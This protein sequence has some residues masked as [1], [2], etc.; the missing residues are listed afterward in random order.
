[1]ATDP[2][3]AVAH[4]VFLA[5]WSKALQST[6]MKHAD[7]GMIQ[8]G[9]AIEARLKGGDAMPDALQPPRNMLLPD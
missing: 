7:V 9:R 4:P 3:P 6:G 5:A 8:R 1:M 2:K